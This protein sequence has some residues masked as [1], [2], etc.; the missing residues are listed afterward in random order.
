MKRYRCVDLLDS[1]PKA[2]EIEANSPDV[3][4]KKFFKLCGIPEKPIRSKAQAHGSSCGRFYTL[5][6]TDPDSEE[7]KIQR[8]LVGFNREGYEFD[9]CSDLEF[10]I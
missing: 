7:Y 2:E 4:M 5:T 9:I 1:W 3:A 6:I 10:E 8:T